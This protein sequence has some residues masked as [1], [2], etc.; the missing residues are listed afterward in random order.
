[1]INYKEALIR[2]TAI[3]ALIALS[4]PGIFAQ[5]DSSFYAYYTRIHSG[6]AFEKDARVGDYADVI[7]NLSEDLK[8]V[9]WMGSSYLPY[10]Q[11]GDST[12][13]LDEV[14]PRSGDGTAE[15]PDIHNRYSYVRIIE[16]QPDRVVVHWRYVPDFSNPTF[17]GTVDEY[18]T[19]TPDLMVERQVRKGTATID[20][21]DDP[22]N[23]F[24]QSLRLG[25]DGIDERTRKMPRRSTGQSHPHNSWNEG[26][27][28]AEDA[29]ISFGFNESAGSS[30]LE[31]VQKQILE[32]TGPKALW[33]NGVSGSCLQF[34]GYY[35]SVALP[36]Y[37]TQEI[38]N[39]ITLEGWVAPG[40]YP[41]D[42]APLVHQSSWERSGFY[43]GLDQLGR[44]GFHVALDGT[45]HSVVSDSALELFKWHH[46]AGTLNEKGEMI[47]YVNGNQEKSSSPGPGSITL[48]NSD[49]LI[50]LNSDKLP[51]GPGRLS[52]GK[53][54]S[55]FGVDG[56]IDE[57][58]VFT[59][60]KLPSEI[61]EGFS[62]LSMT[63]SGINS[64]DME[65]RHWPVWTQEPSQPGFGAHYAKLR[66][67]ETWDHMWRVSDHPDVV[68]TFD[69]NP[70][71]IISWRGL[72]NGPVLVTE[73]NLWVGDQSSENYKEL[74][75]EGEAEGCCEHMS[76]KQCRHA[77]IRII[78]NTAA[79]VV[80]HF[81]YGMV[82]SRYIFPDID[83]KSG[84][85]DWADEI[86]TIYPDGVAVR[87]LERGMIWGDS[88][89]ET[90]FFSAPGQKPEDVVELEAYTVVNEDGESE[91]WS[92]ENGSPDQVFEDV[93]IS[94]VNTR[95]EY[96]AFNVYPSGSSVEVFGGHS[97]G[98]KFH[99]WNHWPVSQITSD[100][101]EASSCDRASHSSLVWG[102]P[103]EP[104]LMYGLTDRAPGALIPLARSWNDPPKIKKLQGA[105]SSGYHQ[106]RRAYTLL[107][108][109]ELIGFTLAGSERS[110]VLNPCF[111]VKNWDQSE[112]AGIRVNGVPIP[113]GPDNR[114]G[115]IRDTDGT[116]TLVVWL[117]QNRR[118]NTLIQI[119]VRK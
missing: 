98:S 89:V 104:F 44:P 4:A 36:E 46:I 60:V 24:T 101:R 18:F 116:R 112:Q 58:K 59:R 102:I 66:Y 57:V 10:L 47:L 37:V 53:Y 106:D 85:G 111:M 32:V 65:S 13:Y 43:L 54:P 55:M 76:D 16:N 20:E 74:D 15:M 22:A 42:W 45:W 77:H 51:L 113:E 115:I 14:I 114:Q 35:S 72:S 19:F 107:R 31:L 103:S 41:F 61:L 30:T 8:V 70:C 73:N 12:W 91:T 33:K 79:R 83:P 29:M 108:E 109:K 94:M 7:V 88:W 119:S 67:Y 81:R 63:A 34:D 110:P 82:D 100:G 38:G 80:L 11:A 49:L 23:V 27:D 117:K 78:E 105:H 71:K 3:V 52:K 90:M 25:P 95:S 96:R 62:E 2:I 97:R 17:T 75:A 99:W 26:S 68:V 50:G 40:A 56:L 48:K 6:E 9:F 87:H 1:M 118:E 84:W 93:V 86:W 28:R 39:E 92:W 21:W 69:N 5:D 64:P